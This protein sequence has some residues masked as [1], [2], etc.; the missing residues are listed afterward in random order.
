MQEYLREQNQLR[1]RE[2]EDR[3]LELFR[4]YNPFI[5]AGLLL[6]FSYGAQ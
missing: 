1:S 6:F 5:D 2:Y 3:G 4:I